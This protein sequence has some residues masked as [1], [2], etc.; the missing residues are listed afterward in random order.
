MKCPR[1]KLVWKVKA[2]A[3]GGKIRW[4]KMTKEQRLA[5]AAKMQE[6][7]RKQVIEARLAKEQAKTQQP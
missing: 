5:W 7:R 4:R 2:Y 3:D 1:C 6:G